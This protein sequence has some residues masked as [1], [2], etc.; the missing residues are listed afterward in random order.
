MALIKKI[1]ITAWYAHGKTYAL[2][3]PD[4]LKEGGRLPMTIAR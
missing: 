4:N 2:R 3:K 1:R